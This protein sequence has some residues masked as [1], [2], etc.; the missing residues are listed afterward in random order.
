MI[1]F[2]VDLTIFLNFTMVVIGTLHRDH[3]ST[4]G[5][6]Q[7]HSFW[8]S[9]MLLPALMEVVYYIDITIRHHY[10][11]KEVLQQYMPTGTCDECE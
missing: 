4:R 5:T 9:K 7:V 2:W 8:A 1:S 11:T 10:T 3:N 6:S